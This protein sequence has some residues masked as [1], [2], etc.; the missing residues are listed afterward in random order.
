MT[1]NAVTPRGPR[2]TTRGLVALSAV[3]ALAFTGCTTA[4]NSNTGAGG[5][6]STDTIRSILTTDPL[7]FSPWEASG[8]DDYLVNG[9]MFA[10]LVYKDDGNSFIPGLASE[11]ETSSE[12]V[13]FTIRDDAT[14]GDGSPVTPSIVAA[15]LTEFQ[16][17]SNVFGGPTFGPA[18]PTISGDDAAGVV[19]VELAQPW[20]DVLS[21]VSLPSAGIVC[22]AGFDDPDALVAGTLDAAVTGPYTLT[23]KQP[24]VKYE[25]T[26]REGY[27]LWPEYAEPLTGTPAQTMVYTIATSSS[28]VANELITGTLDASLISG[29]D[30]ERLEADASLTTERLPSANMFVI[31]NER[32]GSLF[33]DI[34]K[35]RA[36]AQALD[37]EAFNQATNGGLGDLAASYALPAVPCFNTDEALLVETDPTAAAAQLAGLKIRLLGS[38]NFGPNG[39]GNTYIA[40]AL[41][42]TGA[43]VELLNLDNASWAETGQL[44]PEAWDVAVFGNINASATMSGVMG[45]FS[46]APTEDGGANWTG[47]PDERA[48][49][50]LRDAM[51]EPDETKRCDI[52]QEA[53]RY[54][55]TEQVRAVP[56]STLASLVAARDGF[57]FRAPNKSN[58]NY[59]MRIED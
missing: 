2:I 30:I 26:L 21:G 39:A 44:K 10:P 52:Y 55:M 48:Q 23:E 33:A 17:T 3:T 25:F 7:G 24:G 53:Q 29:K 37:R 8:F 50:Y 32:E 43:E 35:R 13:E 28:A 15:S 27:N 42:E 38:Q 51:A 59:A 22:S 9:L 41:R 34:D 40:D 47:N 6:G 5:A 1:R 14:C 4:S 20:S 36:V 54:A 56:L 31:F 46:G 49:Q 19:T 57:S 45:L 58:M 18:A 12:R 11:W 16:K